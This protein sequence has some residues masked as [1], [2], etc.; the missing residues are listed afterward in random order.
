MEWHKPSAGEVPTF[1]TIDL[2]VANPSGYIKNDSTM[3]EYNTWTSGHGGVC[4][5]V[6]DKGSPS[7]WCSQ[8]AAGGW[9]SVKSLLHNGPS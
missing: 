5:T 1:E 4:D 6:W 3:S 7:Y 9:A 2:S 8:G